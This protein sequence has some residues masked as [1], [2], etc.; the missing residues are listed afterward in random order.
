MPH[1]VSLFSTPINIASLDHAM[2][3]HRKADC[4]DW[5]LYEVESPNAGG[6]RGFCHGRMYAKDG[7]LI[8]ST[9]QEGLIRL[10][11]DK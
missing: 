5:N 2:W 9:A 3:F 4:C 6:A 10:Y 7:T 1:D 11:K 8:A